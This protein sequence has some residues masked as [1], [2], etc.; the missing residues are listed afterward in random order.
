MASFSKYYN[1]L[2]KDPIAK[3]LPWV[4]SYL[5]CKCKT[6]LLNAKVFNLP[7]KAHLHWR[8]LLQASRFF[9]EQKMLFKNLSLER[10]L[11][12]CKHHLSDDTTA[13]KTAV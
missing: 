1:F 5:A 12:Q 10:F 4:A 2:K 9:K 3:V 8:K 13:V 11:L 7:V 6:S